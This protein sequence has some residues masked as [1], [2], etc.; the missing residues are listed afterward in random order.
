[1]TGSKRWGD[2]LGRKKD[3]RKAGGRRLVGG[4][5]DRKAKDR[6]GLDNKVP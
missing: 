2:S 4:H 1:M 3:V 5:V 6:L